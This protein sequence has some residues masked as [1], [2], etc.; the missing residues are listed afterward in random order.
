VSIF[1][2]LGS[3]LADPKKQ[4]LESLDRLSAIRG[5][6]IV[7][8]SSLYRGEPWGFRDQPAFYNAVV[9]I[10][11]GLEPRALLDKLL[12]IERAMGRK[13]LKIRWGPRRID[14]DLLIY[15]A[16]RILEPGLAIPHPHIRER[17]FVLIPLLE[18]APNA[19]EPGTARP[20][21]PSLARL[22]RQGEGPCLVEG[23]P[24]R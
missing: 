8:C 20:Y 22:L 21:A 10:A 1:V 9:Q 12:G 14:L 13:P 2:G 16:R 11:T 7:R 17:A 23:L 5:I 3:N 19:G 15:H 4:I 6:E 24:S 18:I